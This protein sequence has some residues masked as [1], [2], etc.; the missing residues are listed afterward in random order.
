[1]HNTETT[2]KQY[3]LPSGLLTALASKY[4]YL[5]ETDIVKYALLKLLDS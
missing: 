3:R 4:P 5:K 2:P 1:M